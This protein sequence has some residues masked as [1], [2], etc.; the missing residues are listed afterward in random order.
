MKYEKDIFHKISEFKEEC[1]E[2]IRKKIRKSLCDNPLKDIIIC[3]DENFTEDVREI[4][5]NYLESEGFI[6]IY[7][8]VFS[9]SIIGIKVE[10]PTK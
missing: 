7:H 3:Y 4:V 8:K 10:I 5:C 2:M 6:V 9:S 1:Y